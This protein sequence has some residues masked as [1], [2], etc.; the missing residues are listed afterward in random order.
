MSAVCPYCSVSVATG[1]ARCIE[2]QLELQW[3][4][5]GVVAHHPFIKPGEALFF[6]DAIRGA[7]PGRE[8]LAG[9]LTDGT[10]YGPSP[11]GALVTVGPK[12]V[13]EAFEARQ[14]VRDGCVRASFIAIDAGVTVSCM[15][16]IESVGD[17]MLKYVLQVDPAQGRFCLQRGF[18]SHE[19]AQFTPLVP[20][21]ASPAV[22]PLGHPN[23]IELRLQG[24]TIEARLNDRHVGTIHDP[25]L[26][27]GAAGLR[28]SSTSNATTMLRA[29][30]QWFELREVIA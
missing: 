30:V 4:P 24:P 20:W 25:V 5:A 29:V 15:G 19:S 3:G 11:Q 12:R 21:T 6:C 17:A 23:V 14:R 2:C 1:L 26:G 27:I 13:F 22:A 18:S 8:V 10:T 7:L 9:K 28:V 16:R